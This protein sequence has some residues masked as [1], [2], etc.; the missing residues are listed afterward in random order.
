M[1]EHKLITPRDVPDD[2]EGDLCDV[3]YMAHIASKLLE[4]AV[5]DR[6]VHLELTG[7]PNLY[8]INPDCIDAMIFAVYEV[9][10]RIRALKAKYLG[11]KEQADFDGLSPPA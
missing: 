8:H 5:G 11:A 1:S 9:E 7:K 6:N 3:V 4:D 10:R 2:I